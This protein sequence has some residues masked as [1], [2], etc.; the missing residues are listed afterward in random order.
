MIRKAKTKNQVNAL[1]LRRNKSLIDV[2]KKSP[3][4][5]CQGVVGQFIGCYLQCEVLATKIQHFYQKDN[6][7]EEN[8]LNTKA[9]TD[10]LAHFNMHYS[11]ESLM[12]I[13]SGGKG[14]RGSKSARQL[15]NGYL[16]QLSD[17]DREEIEINGQGL[18]GEMKN[19]LKLRIKS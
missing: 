19:F 18:I 12:H 6:S 7:H 8:Q 11:N 2:E 5:D 3:G 13:F 10:A 17:S 9:L 4:F 16:H 1:N 15:R 14:K